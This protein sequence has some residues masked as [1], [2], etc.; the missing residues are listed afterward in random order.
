MN[1]T[2]SASLT[3]SGN[4]NE[5][6]PRGVSSS[7]SP[8]FPQQNE[9]RDSSQEDVTARAITITLV[10]EEIL[11]HRGFPHGGINE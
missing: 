3:R 7:S 10:L 4:E 8:F 5:T 9:R 6:F 11:S 2:T 1:V